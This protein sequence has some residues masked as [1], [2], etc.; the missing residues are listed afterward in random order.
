MFDHF[1][2]D[3]DNALTLQELKD[4]CQGLNIDLTDEEL[5]SV[6]AKRGRRGSTER[7]MTFNA[8]SEFMVDQLKTGSS[9]DDVL[10]A[11][12]ELAG[13][14]TITNDQIGGYFTSSDTAEYLNGH[15][16]ASGDGS[17]YDYIKYTDTMFSL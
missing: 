8:F 14:P 10:T 2:V 3:K 4:G 9:A 17:G 11:W 6:M 15:M 1:D 5:E 16:P 7:C 13:A 12:K